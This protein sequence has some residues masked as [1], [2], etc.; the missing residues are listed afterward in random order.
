[1]GLGLTRVLEEDLLDG[2]VVEVLVPVVPLPAREAQVPAGHRQVRLRPVAGVCAH[3]APLPL[4][5]N[6]NTETL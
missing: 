6:L 1:M 3:R 5:K 2:G 4:H